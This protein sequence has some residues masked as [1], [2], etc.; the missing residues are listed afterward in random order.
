LRTVL[1]A[2]RADPAGICRRLV[3]RSIEREHP[4]NQLD[5]SVQLGRKA[6]QGSD[7][8][9]RPAADHGHPKPT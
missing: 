8:R 2:R 1:S 3:S 9:I 5:F 4:C 7:K 6:M